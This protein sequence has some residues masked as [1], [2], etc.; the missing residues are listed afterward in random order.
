[1]AD[2]RDTA[3]LDRT[4]LEGTGNLL[5]LTDNE[6]L[7]MLLCQR[8]ADSLGRDHVYRWALA[9]EATGAQNPGQVVWSK[10]PRPS[11]LSAEIARGEALV[12]RRGELKRESPVGTAIAAVAGGRFVLDPAGLEPENDKN[13]SAVLYVRREADYLLRAIR[14]ELVL[15][16]DVADQRGLFEKLMH[17]IVQLEPKVPRDATVAELLER[18]RAFPTALG[19]GIAVPHAYV[20]AL[21]WRLCAVARIPGGLE[22]GAPDGQKI[23]LAFL[24]LSPQGDPEG[25]L[26]TMAEIAR[27]VSD[28]SM[29]DRLLNAPTREDMMM[30]LRSF[31]PG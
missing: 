21:N 5:A 10:L 14:P 2:A 8:W 30:C 13:V 9:G 16:I 25:H 12:Q 27:M 29:R 24:L 22:F 11:L 26:A 31:R 7:N 19:H 17:R 28:Q 18:E 1:M 15:E 6:N 23:R 3:L 20:K 4:E